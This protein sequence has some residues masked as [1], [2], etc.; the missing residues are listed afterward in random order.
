MGAGLGNPNF[1]SEIENSYNT[2]RRDGSLHY[3]VLKRT[4]RMQPLVRTVKTT[5]TQFL[6]SDPTA[7]KCKVIVNG[8]LYGLDM[9]G[10]AAVLRGKPDDPADTSVQG[11]VVENG[12]VIAGDRRPESFWFGQVMDPTGRTPWTC[13]AGKGDPP[14]AVS[15]L[16]AIGGVGPLIVGSLPYGSGN[17]YKP[18]APAGLPEPKTGEPPPETMPYM[19]QRNNATFVDA[20]GK[21]P[22][23]AKTILAYCSAKGAMLV[24]VQQHGEAPGETHAQIYHGPR[25]AR[26]RCG[27]VPGWQRQRHAG[28]GW[29]SRCRSRRTEE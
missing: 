28:S 16:A 9:W 22:Q 20:S 18:G 11:Q 25:A 21:P 1:W 17:L 2:L 15:T 23:T 3:I 12:R 19:I 7:K 10:T 24:A 26:L 13:K 27:G 29:H 14:V 8:N 6:A 5:F 4:Y